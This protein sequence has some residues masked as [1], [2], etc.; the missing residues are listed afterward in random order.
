MIK[1]KILLFVLLLSC[2]EKEMTLDEKMAVGVWDEINGYKSWTQPG[3]FSGIQGSN[4]VHGNYVQ[5]WLN[6][7]SSEFFHDTTAGEIMPSG[8]IIIK[9]TYSDILG[10]NTTGITVM[11]K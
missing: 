8:S 6:E 2:S 4:S 9:E 3:S 1:K 10:E 5:I 11:K 7:I